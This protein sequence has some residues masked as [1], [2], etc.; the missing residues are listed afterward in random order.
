MLRAPRGVAI[1]AHSHFFCLPQAVWSQCNIPSFPPRCNDALAVV[2][3]A[4]C[5]R[6]FTQ[7]PA[8]CASAAIVPG[9]GAPASHHGATE[10]P[11]GATTDNNA[12]A[13][14]RAGHPAA[15][16]QSPSDPHQ[17]RPRPRPAAAGRPSLGPS[18]P[19]A[20]PARPLCAAEPPALHD[21]PTRGDTRTAHSRP[22]PAPNL[23]RQPGRPPAP[24]PPS[25]S[26]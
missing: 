4:V 3:R 21:A 16:A 14:Q 13:P 5:S 17:Q 1:A 2:L 12:H 20:P 24:S 23:R 25:A 11:H 22:I 18:T 26:S 6:A 7:E 8:F 15:L 9:A 10:T 19:K